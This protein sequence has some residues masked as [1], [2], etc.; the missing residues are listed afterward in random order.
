MSA[1]STSDRDSFILA[2]IGLVKVIAKSIQDSLPASLD[3]HK[4]L[5]NS[6]IVGLITA[7]DQYDA[8]RNV[9]FGAYAAL[10]IRWEIMESLRRLDTLTRSQRKKLRD[11]HTAENAVG[12]GEESIAAFLKIT[13][14]EVR[15]ARAVPVTV[16]ISSRNG[17]SYTGDALKTPLVSS[18][19]VSASFVKSENLRILE[20]AIQSLP[21]RWACVIRMKMEGVKNKEIG[22]ILGFNESRTSQ[23][24]ASSIESMRKVWGK[25]G[26]RDT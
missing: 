8:S 16:G 3:L 26:S 7:V 19:D 1:C 23:I 10:L 9:P 11:L 17:Q 2:N 5:I 12:C 13:T 24:Y 15:A 6:G 4:D 21:S 18:Y 22:R 20:E 25:T 14:E